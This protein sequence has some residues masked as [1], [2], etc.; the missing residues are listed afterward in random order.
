MVQF[1]I[2]LLIINLSTSQAIIGYDCGS[3][4]SNVS[5]IALTEVKECS[6]TEEEVKIS[7]VFIEL[8]QANKYNKV[9]IT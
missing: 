7:D 4:L 3:S 1:P 9:P 8:L 2:L 5:T 6:Q